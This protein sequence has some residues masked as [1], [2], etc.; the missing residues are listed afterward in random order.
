MVSSEKVCPRRTQPAGLC[1]G[2]TLIVISTP[3]LHLL[4]P[5][6]NHICSIRSQMH[7]DGKDQTFRRFEQITVVISHWPPET[8]K[9]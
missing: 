2:S 4:A 6:P 5:N 7:Q 9:K 3:P 8:I 1:R